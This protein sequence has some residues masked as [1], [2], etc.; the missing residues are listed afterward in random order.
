MKSEY[1]LLFAT[2]ARLQVPGLPPSLVLRVLARGE[3]ERRRC[4][5]EN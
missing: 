4:S 5:E 2:N 1:C 3:G